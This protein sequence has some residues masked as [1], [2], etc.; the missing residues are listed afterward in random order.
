MQ[1]WTTLDNVKRFTAAVYAISRRLLFAAC[2]FVQPLLSA[3]RDASV[4]S[5]A[6]VRGITFASDMS[7]I[8]A[9]HRY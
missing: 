6:T 7:V 2:S 9:Q 5:R 3:L 1:L 4:V 8:G